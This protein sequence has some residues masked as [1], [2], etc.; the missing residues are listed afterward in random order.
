VFKSTPSRIPNGLRGEE[1][2]RDK[3]NEYRTLFFHSTLPLTGISRGARRHTA[4]TIWGGVV[5]GGNRENALLKILEGDLYRIIGSFKG[6]K[7][8]PGESLHIIKGGP[9][10]YSKCIKREWKKNV[11]GCLLNLGGG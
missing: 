8:F 2:T 7:E 9:Q 1:I 10:V 5:T 6:M 3:K 4:L 11:L